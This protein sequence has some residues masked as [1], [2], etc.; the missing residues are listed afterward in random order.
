[1]KRKM[2]IEP[3][4]YNY[5][6]SSLVGSKAKTHGIIVIFAPNC[7]VTNKQT[8]TS[9]LSLPLSLTVCLT[10]CLS[11]TRYVSCLLRHFSISHDTA[12]QPEQSNLRNHRKPLLCYVML[13]PR[14]VNLKTCTFAHIPTAKDGKPSGHQVAC[15][16][17]DS[18]HKNPDAYCLTASMHVPPI[19]NSSQLPPRGSSIMDIRK[20]DLLWTPFIPSSAFGPS[21]PCQSI[22]RTSTLQQST[23]PGLVAQEVVL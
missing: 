21:Y 11:G 23:W 4:L 20:Y 12:I 18:Q 1:M 17:T 10:V 19:L 16:F 7:P 15:Y 22:L 9:L 6:A 8:V 13:Y 5:I 3:L 14:L 2:L